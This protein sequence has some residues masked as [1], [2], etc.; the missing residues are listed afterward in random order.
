M[1][2]TDLEQDV[3]VGFNSFVRGRSGSRLTIGRNSIIMPH[4][5]I[6]IK[7][8]M[9]IPAD[10]MVWGLITGKNDLAT[11]SI[12]LDTLSRVQSS[13]SRGNMVFE[14]SGANFVKA[15]KARIHHILEANGAFFDGK[16][17]RGHAQR[18]QKISFNTIQ[19]YPEGD[20]EGLYPTIDIQP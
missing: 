13:I 8:P 6:D 20:K 12:S 2:E 14:G 15:F 10:H 16:E 9:R 5:I 3:F 7:R 4:T 1:I 18:N 11:N 17:N 19:P